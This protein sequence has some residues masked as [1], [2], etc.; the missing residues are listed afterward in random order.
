MSRRPDI[1]EVFDLIAAR[2]VEDG[3]IYVGVWGGED[4]EGFWIGILMSRSG[5]FL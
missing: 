1:G 5:F 2:L 4:F 3:L